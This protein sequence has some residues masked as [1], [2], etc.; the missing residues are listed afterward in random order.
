MSFSFMS[1]SYFIYLTT[2]TTFF[3]SLVYKSTTF[4]VFPMLH[5]HFLTQIKIHAMQDA[6]EARVFHIIGTSLSAP[7]AIDTG[8]DNATGKA[9]AL[10]TRE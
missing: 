5:Y 10:A 1:I 9:R 2:P 7:L 3:I 6:L 8:R 4:S